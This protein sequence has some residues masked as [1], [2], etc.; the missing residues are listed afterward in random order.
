M[1]LGFLFIFHLSQKSLLSLEQQV[2]NIDLIIV[3]TMLSSIY[4]HT[5]LVPMQILVPIHF[6]QINGN[7]ND[8]SQNWRKS[9]KRWN[10]KN[11]NLCIYPFWC[12]INTFLFFGNDEA[13]KLRETGFIT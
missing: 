13:E 10:Y 3:N 11:M 12:A 9:N 7:G 1:S 5:D 8:L 6:Y 4:S 2:Q